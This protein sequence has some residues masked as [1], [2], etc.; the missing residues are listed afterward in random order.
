MTRG[1]CGYTQTTEK[2]LF[3]PFYCYW[4]SPGSSNGKE[5][6]YYTGEPRLVPGLG[7]PLKKGMATHSVFFPEKSHRQR[8]L[9]G[10][11]PW[12]HKGS[13]MTEQLTLSHF[14]SVSSEGRCNRIPHTGWLSAT[15]MCC[16]TLWVLEVRVKMSAGLVPPRGVQKH[17]SQT[18]LLTWGSLRHSLGSFCTHLRVQIS[19]FVLPTANWH[20]PASS[21][22]AET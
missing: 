6:A 8:S 16:P 5:S 12:G 4:G 21:P 3:S 20:L 2:C 15:E 9:E 22:R 14:T 18:A 13:D 11:T 19:P 1:T 7:N 17:V 10:Y